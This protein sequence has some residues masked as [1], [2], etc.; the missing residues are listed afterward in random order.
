MDIDYLRFEG[1]ILTGIDDLLV[2]VREY[3]EIGVYRR[4]PKSLPYA[5]SRSNS[6]NGFSEMGIKCSF[7]NTSQPERH[8]TSAFIHI[9]VEEVQPG[10]QREEGK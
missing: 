7:H 6:F 8:P 5:R 10:R 1:G 4:P 2:L 9:S 3:G